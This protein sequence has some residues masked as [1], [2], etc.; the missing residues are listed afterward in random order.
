MKKS[1]KRL[2]EYISLGFVYVSAG[3]TIIALFLIFSYII[4]KG[5]IYDNRV[6]YQV[7]SVVDTNIDGLYVIVNKGNSLT[8]LS[9]S[10]LRNIFS[11]KSVNWKKI[12][13][14]VSDIAPLTSKEAEKKIP[15]LFKKKGFLTETFAEPFAALQFTAQNKSAICLIEKNEYDLAH[16][17]LSKSDKKKIKILSLRTQALLCNEA[18]VALHGNFK[19]GTLKEK[20]ALHIFKGKF[21]NWNELGGADIPIKP[22]HIAHVDDNAKDIFLSELNQTEGACGFAP[23]WWLLDKNAKNVSFINVSRQE[24]GL[25]LKLGYLFEPAVEGGKYG[26]ISS[27]L[28]NTFIMIILTLIL[29]VPPGVLGAVYL[30]EYGKEGKLMRILRLG[31]ET[32]A[33]IPS[34]IFGLFG[35]LVFVQ[36]L[37]WGISLLSGSFTLM[38]MILPTIIRTSEEA[39]KSVSPALKEGSLALGAS[40]IQTIFKVVLPTA[41][42]SIGAGVI[43]A[44]GRALGETAA[45]IYTMGSNY[46]LTHGLF[47]STRTLAVHL[48]LLIA[49]GISTD[50]AFASATVLILFIL[51]INRLS[52]YVINRFSAR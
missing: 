20:D 38:L 41:L 8:E 40:K 9:Y 37:G 44:I 6:E 11:G 13:G 3:F 26:G 14:D 36:G 35:M 17:L 30:I 52:K 12:N 15:T 5:L 48:Y 46:N 4:F 31:T 42:P 34:I 16:E 29:S 33:G 1:K 45:L 19:L 22:V 39:I 23:A 7:N 24:R 27:I 2:S 32:L 21:T 28:G 25:N 47:D 51:L 18:V 10:V 43:L 50:K 49:E